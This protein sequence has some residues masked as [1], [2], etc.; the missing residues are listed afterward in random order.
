MLRRCN[1]LLFVVSLLVCSFT[2]HAADSAIKI[3]VVFPQ[4]LEP[5]KVYMMTDG[6]L[7][8]GLT[9]P[10]AA[11]ANN[12]HIK[13]RSEE[14][15]AQLDATLE[16]YDRY[17]VVHQALAKR[18]SQRSVAFELT[19]SREF[20]KYVSSKGITAS[21]GADDFSY[22]VAIEDKFS[23]MS[24]LNV[25]TKTDD[26][27]P[28]TTLGYQVF[29]TKKRSRISKG[30]VSANGLQKKPFKEAIGDKAFFTNAYPTLAD[31]IA[32]QI[33]GTLFRT[34]VLHAM[35]ASAG[36]GDEVPQVSSVLKKNEKRFDYEFTPAKNW[37]RTKMNV[38][39]ANLLEPK[40]DLRYSMGLRFDVDLLV[41][42]LGQDVTSIDE[43]VPIYLTRLEDSGVDTSTFT[44]F[45]EINARPEYRVY[46]FL[47]NNDGGR[48]IVLLRKVGD[49]LLEMI[50]VVFSKD[51]ETLY[52]AHRA[53]IEQMIA[54]AKLKVN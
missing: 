34:D 9:I 26:L 3:L 18:F 25:A 20:D 38:K 22:V 19:Q 16:G 27:A 5:S 49:D 6:E 1:V 40:S 50:L 39:Y 51:F 36:R 31:N 10:F 37:K 4:Q 7:T 28:Y 30:A 23:G 2:V 14:L 21:A 11:I 41:P 33:V 48:Q 43:Y 32:N 13:K 54:D 46:S 29:E 52:P 15:G 17:D 24:I 12:A 47:P 45:T 8:R 44:E 42:E 35:A 53:D